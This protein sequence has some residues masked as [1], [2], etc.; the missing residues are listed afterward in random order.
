MDVPIEIRQELQELDQEIRFR[1]QLMMD[2]L[3]PA[4][5]DMAEARM[6]KE[7]IREAGQR[8]VFLQ[9]LYPQLVIPFLSDWILD[10]LFSV[11]ARG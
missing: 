10:C 7:S 8:I 11:D 1:A 9:R 6:L 3:G 2:A 4:E 5:V